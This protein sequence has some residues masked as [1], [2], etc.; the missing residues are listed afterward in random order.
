MN[1][2]IVERLNIYKKFFKILIDYARVNISFSITYVSLLM[3]DS[4]AK[5]FSIISMAPL[6][7]F[8]SG[9]NVGTQQITLFFTA[10]N[11]FSAVFDFY[12]IYGCSL[13]NNNCNTC[14]FIASPFFSPKWPYRNMF[15]SFNSLVR[16]LGTFSFYTCCIYNFFLISGN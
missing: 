8:L 15:V 12:W 9:D 6:V 3:L 1:K 7:D 11:T 14:Y 2:N 4:F 5:I 16:D 13:C 10:L